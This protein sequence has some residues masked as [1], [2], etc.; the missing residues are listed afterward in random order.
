MIISAKTEYA[1]IAILE[2]AARHGSGEPVRI[3]DI[4][5][6]HGVPSRFLVQI[7]LQLKSAG[8]VNSIRGAAGGYQLA[9]EPDEISLL[10]VMAVVDPDLTQVSG[11]A[12]RSTGATR[13]LQ[14]TWKR[15]AAAE[16][17]LLAGV[18][19]S[20]LVEQLKGAPEGMYYI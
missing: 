20:D 7:L 17:E 5:E 4:A 1:C 3:R 16:R 6:A 14:R 8:L 12:T 15:V 11:S 10:D 2:L 13:T 9:K 19:F 18:T